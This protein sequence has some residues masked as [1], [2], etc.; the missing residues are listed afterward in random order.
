MK[1]R[2]LPSSQNGGMAISASAIR[3]REYGAMVAYFNFGLKILSISDFSAGKS[4][5]FAPARRYIMSRSASICAGG[6]TIGSALTPSR[7]L[8]SLNH[9]VGNSV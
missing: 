4:Y 2:I 1:V 6:A 5:D 3:G 8:T 7:S 9:M